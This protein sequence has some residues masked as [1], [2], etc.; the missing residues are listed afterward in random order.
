[1]DPVAALGVA[2]A[3]VHTRHEVPIKMND[4]SLRALKQAF[5]SLIKNTLGKLRFCFFIDGLDEY[6]GD[7]WEISEYFCELSNLENVKF[8]L[9]SRPEIAFLDV[10]GNVPQLRLQDLTASDIAIY[11]GDKLE[12]NP[13]MQ[14]LMKTSPENSLTLIGDVVYAGDGVFLWVWEALLTFTSDLEFDPWFTWSV[15]WLHL[16]EARLRP[17]PEVWELFGKSVRQIRSTKAKL[18]V[19]KLVEEFDRVA[20]R[21]L[22][23]TM[24]SDRQLRHDSDPNF[25][26]SD[27]KVYVDAEPLTF[28][29]WHSLIVDCSFKL[30]VLF[31]EN[32]ADFNEIYY[33]HSLWKIW[34]HIMHNESENLYRGWREY[35]PL[36]F[37][38]M[39][40]MLQREADLE[41]CCFKE[42]TIWDKI[43]PDRYYGAQQM[44]DHCKQS[45]E[46]N[47]RENEGSQAHFASEN[48][49]EP[50]EV[51]HSL[52]RIIKDIFEEECPELSAK[53]LDLVAEKKAEKLA[54]EKQAQN[55]SS[56]KKGRKQKQR[57]KKKSKGKCR[58]IAEAGDDSD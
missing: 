5:K 45:I 29:D 41:V 43:Y 30:L 31:L 1:M 55:L 6:E 38:A 28:L 52:M 49:D 18:L 8:C 58:I 27:K 25:D 56:G 37:R 24:P 4:W 3:V 21:E 23:S 32:N 26:T 42:S 57:N 15:V 47:G 46:L 48:E 14:H 36:A 12:N 17:I 20:Q 33:G 7:Y 22:A 19:P 9:S 39:E 44:Q 34:I 51:R 13:Q 2:A 40:T 54:T 53:L 35:L 11:V 10:F 50:W 16:L